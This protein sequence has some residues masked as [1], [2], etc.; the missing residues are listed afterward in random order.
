MSSAEG[1]V[2]PPEAAETWQAEDEREVEVGERMD[3]QKD[4]RTTRATMA[5]TSVGDPGKA[6]S[7]HY[8]GV[9]GVYCCLG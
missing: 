5:S 4:G 2:S 6:Q 9:D 3:E 7:S 8:L 1:V